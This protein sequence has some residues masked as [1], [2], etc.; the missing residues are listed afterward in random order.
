[1]KKKKQMPMNQH[2]PKKGKKKKEADMCIALLRVAF[3]HRG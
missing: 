1:M 2:M 3:S